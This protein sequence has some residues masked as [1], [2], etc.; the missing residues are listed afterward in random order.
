MSPTAMNSLSVR[1][2]SCERIAAQFV[3]LFVPHGEKTLVEKNSP[4]SRTMK[5]S[6]IRRPANFGNVHLFLLRATN[7]FSELIHPLLKLPNCAFKQPPHILQLSEALGSAFSL[8]E[9]QE[10]ALSS[11]C[12]F[13]SFLIYTREQRSRLALEVLDTAFTTRFET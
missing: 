7:M 5:S 1:V 4:S 6:L 10:Q 3:T 8:F 13:R 9:E 2:F 12:H 11:Y